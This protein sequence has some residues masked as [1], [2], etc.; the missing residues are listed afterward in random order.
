MMA[1]VQKKYKHLYQEKQLRPGRKS[2]TT[3]RM[4][5]SLRKS[6]L[7]NYEIWHSIEGKHI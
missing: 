2:W 6:L 4:N 5:V 1:G 7:K 3:S